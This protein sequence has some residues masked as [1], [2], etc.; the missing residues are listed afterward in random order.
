MAGILLLRWRRRWRPAAWRQEIGLATHWV[1]DMMTDDSSIVP[2]VK[3]LL[4]YLR[5][6]GARVIPGRRR[7]SSGTF[8]L[9]AVRRTSAGDATLADQ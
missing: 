9:A 2:G 5:T 6:G 1:R 7:L 4:T 8:L 3:G